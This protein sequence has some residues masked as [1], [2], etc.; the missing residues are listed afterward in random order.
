MMLYYAYDY[1]ISGLSP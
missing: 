1:M